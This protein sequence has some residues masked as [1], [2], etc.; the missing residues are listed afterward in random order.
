M[1]FDVEVTGVTGDPLDVEDAIQRV[2]YHQLDNEVEV[3]YDNYKVDVKMKTSPNC[4]TDRNFRMAMRDMKRSRKPLVKESSDDI[5]T[6]IMAYL[7]AAR[8]EAENRG[9]YERDE[10]DPTYQTYVDLEDS[11]RKEGLMDDEVEMLLDE[12]VNGAWL[13][14]SEL[15]YK[16]ETRIDTEV[17]PALFD[18]LGIE[19]PVNEEIDLGWEIDARRDDQRRR[20]S[21]AQG[22]NDQELIYGGRP[23]KRINIVRRLRAAIS[24]YEDEGYD[25][26]PITELIEKV[27]KAKA[28]DEIEFPELQKLNEGRKKVMKEGN[29][30]SSTGPRIYVGTYGKYN[31]GSIDGDWVDIDDFD[32]YEDFVDHCRELHK[33]EKDPEFMVQDYEGYPEAWYHESGLPTEDE[34]YRMKEISELSES[35]K[36]AYAAF[37]S[38]GYRNDSIENFREHYHG[39]Y[40]NDSDFGYDTVKSFG[41]DGVGEENLEWYFDYDSFGRDLMYDYH[42]GDPDNTDSEGEPEDDT[43]YYDNDGYDLG[44]YS[45]DRRVAEDFIDGMGGVKELGKETLQRYFDYEAYGHSLLM[46]DFTEVDGYV[47]WNN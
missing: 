1:K 22:F 42:M 10:D 32:N 2:I 26:A 20:I 11:I 5:Y 3:D 38:L 27:Y 30:G 45:G 14:D 33:D 43:H 36:G 13:Y 35:E 29:E 19:K 9:E 47:F 34:F 8:S 4:K 21:D 46:N 15:E 44:E 31:D 17:L 16:G 25:I 7:D 39:T 6:K 18:K 23:E 37:L 24:N 40:N 41:W 12:L 28:G